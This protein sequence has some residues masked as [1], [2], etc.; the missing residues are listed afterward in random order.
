MSWEGKGERREK[1]KAARSWAMK[2]KWCRISVEC[3]WQR[4]GRMPRRGED[5]YRE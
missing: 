3:R 4:Q 5:R 2:E 1:E